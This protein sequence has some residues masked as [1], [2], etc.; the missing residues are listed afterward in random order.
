MKIKEI[1]KRY[2]WGWG[3]P[4]R[5]KKKI[6]L[7]KNLRVLVIL[8]G[9]KKWLVLIKIILIILFLIIKV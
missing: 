8:G 7:F 2:V 3:K 4:G 9:V 5:D 1:N 6:R